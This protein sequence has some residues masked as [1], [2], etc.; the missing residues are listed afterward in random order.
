VF[1]KVLPARADP[2]AG[3]PFLPSVRLMTL[4]RVGHDSALDA[5]GQAEA[6]RLVEL[7]VARG[8]LSRPSR[9]WSRGRYQ[10]ALIV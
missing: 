7:V 5:D 8:R 2:P 4:S 1:E 6:Q 9:Y 10:L 3:V